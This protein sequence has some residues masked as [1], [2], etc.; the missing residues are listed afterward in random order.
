MLDKGTI[1]GAVVVVITQTF[2]WL[3]V[4]SQHIWSGFIFMS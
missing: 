2:A 3:S 4:T 1:K